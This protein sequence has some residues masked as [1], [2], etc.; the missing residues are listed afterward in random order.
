MKTIEELKQEHA[1]ELEKVQR[2]HEIAQGLPI[3]PDHVMLTG[4]APW[5]TYKV[6]TLRGAAEIFEVFARRGAIRNMEH[7]KGTFTHLCP[8]SERGRDQ[9][10]HRGD[11]CGALEVTQG[12]GYGPNVRLTFYAETHNGL[13][14]ISVQLEERLPKFGAHVEVERYK[15]ATARG[16][17]SQ[18]IVKQSFHRNDIL[19]GYANGYI[20]YASGDSG[21]IKK[22]ALF[23][24]MWVADDGAEC[25]VFDHFLESLENLA[26]ELEQ[27]AADEAARAASEGQLAR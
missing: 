18:R 27:P 8:A 11:F 13:C 14:K 25:T 4:R 12:E 5:V 2:E 21:P 19:N 20:S 9:V 26:A 1:K 16:R 6:K 17:D 22:S 10:V 23:V 24:Y 15:G 7:A 3:P